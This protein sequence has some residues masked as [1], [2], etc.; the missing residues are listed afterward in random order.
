MKVD[1]SSPLEVEGVRENPV[2]MMM[3][4]VQTSGGQRVG[5]LWDGASDTNYITY[6]LAKKLHLQGESFTLVINGFA[7]MQTKVETSRYVVKL[8]TVKGRLVKFI[9]YGVESVANVSKGVN[10]S[11]ITEL[12]PEQSRRSLERPT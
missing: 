2:V 9:V 6:N 3:Q 1:K 5:A 12:F 8:K 7:G 10:M 11:V 4:F